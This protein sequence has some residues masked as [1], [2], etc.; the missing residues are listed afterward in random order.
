[1]L[2][3]KVFLKINVSETSKFGFSS[4]RTAGFT[5]EELKEAIFQMLCG[6][7]PGIDGIPVEFYQEFWE[8]IKEHYLNFIMICKYI[9][10]EIYLFNKILNQI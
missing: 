1:M 8:L 5:R 10:T 3:F 9:L 7:S 4:S 2:L 6:K